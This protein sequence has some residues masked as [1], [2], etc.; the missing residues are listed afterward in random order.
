MVTPAIL[1]GLL[2]PGEGPL[3][4]ERSHESLPLWAALIPLALAIPC[5]VFAALAMRRRRLLDMV[6][7]SKV[8]GVF[9][10]LSEVKGEARKPVPLV[11]YL[12]GV[13]CVWYSYAIEEHWRRTVTETYTDSEGRTRTRNRVETGWKTVQDATV[14]RPFFLEDDTGSIRIVPDR[15]KIDGKGVFSKRV[16]RRDPLYYGK[17]PR[18][19][20]ADST[21]ERR[22]SEQAIPIDSRLYVLGTARLR[23]DGLTPEVG[24]TRADRTLVVST[25]SE[26]K[27]ARG[28]AFS[29]WSLTVLGCLLGA[30]AGGC[31]G[32]SIRPAAED[33]GTFV[34]RNADL[35]IAGAS[36]CALLMGAWHGIQIYNG[37]VYLRQ[38]LRNALSQIDIQLKRR[39]VLIPRLVSVVKAYAT[40]ERQVLEQL[41]RARAGGDGTDIRATEEAADEQTQSF[42]RLLGI[43]EAHP[44]LGSDLQYRALMRRLVKTEDRIAHARAFYN[45]SVNVHN[46]RIEVFPD[47]LVA[48]LARF[49]AERPLAFDDLSEA[50]ELLRGSGP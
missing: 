47:V 9:L 27:I 32:A 38:R 36:L 40:H 17:G 41:A 3:P 14:T 1:V 5:L 19:S 44:E 2:Q 42:R 33:F 15:G 29:F 31:L 46:R 50:D 6:P 7:T 48:R 24:W 13:D 8:A 4:I 30:V 16:R 28:H 22:F 35:L 37:L 18:R 34:A 20:V 39:H 12:A 43:V 10:G 49:R 11:S 25:R 23:K 21:H 45:E 26:E